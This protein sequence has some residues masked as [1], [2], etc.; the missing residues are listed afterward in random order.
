ME[1]MNYTSVLMP[2]KSLDDLVTYLNVFYNTLQFDVL[3]LNFKSYQHIFRPCQQLFNHVGTISCF[4]WV[5]L[6]HKS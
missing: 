3:P 5:G 4:F 2:F 6:V 1:K